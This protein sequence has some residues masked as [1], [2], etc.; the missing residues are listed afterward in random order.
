ME[1]ESRLVVTGGCMGGGGNGQLLING[2]KIS[3]MQDE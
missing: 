2:H 1:S 3:I